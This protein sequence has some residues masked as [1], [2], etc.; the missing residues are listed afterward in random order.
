ME[1]QPLVPAFRDIDE[2]VV[3]SGVEVL[4]L[5]SEVEFETLLRDQLS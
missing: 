4:L 5:I 1:D 2:D 3:L